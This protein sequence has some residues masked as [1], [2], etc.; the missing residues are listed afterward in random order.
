MSAVKLHLI[1]TCCP[2]GWFVKHAR[3]DNDRW[4]G[5]I[6]SRQ[7][8]RKVNNWEER[9]NIYSRRSSSWKSDVCRC[10]APRRRLLSAGNTC[11]GHV[12][13][14]MVHSYTLQPSTYKRAALPRLLIADEC[15]GCPRSNAASSCCPR[16][17]PMKR[18]RRAVRSASKPIKRKIMSSHE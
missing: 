9:I 16:P 5:D 10:S 4:C 1:Y 11:Q 2:A 15:C 3:T 13:E 18:D 8:I 7:F 17:A 12:H 6:G 14:Q